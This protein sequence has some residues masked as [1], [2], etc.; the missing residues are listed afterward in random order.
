MEELHDRLDERVVRRIA[1]LQQGSVER[2]LR[3]CRH[4]RSQE[5]ALRL[6]RRHGC[7]GDVAVP[8]GCLVVAELRVAAQF[9]PEMVG[10]RDPPTIVEMLGE[11]DPVQ[12]GLHSKLVCT[13]VGKRNTLEHEIR[14]TPLAIHA[15]GDQHAEGHLQDVLRVNRFVTEQQSYRSALVSVGSDSPTEDVVSKTEMGVVFDGASGFLKWGQLWNSCHQVVILD[16]T[17]PYFDDAISAINTRFSQRRI[18]GDAALPG[19]DA[20]PGGEVI[21]FR[22]AVE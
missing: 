20:P 7:V 2:H 5:T 4:V 12:L 10:S 1:R 3:P 21:A 16:R 9:E 19:S 22:E 17:E 6:D 8:R 11:A 15:N 13:L 14:H 18:E